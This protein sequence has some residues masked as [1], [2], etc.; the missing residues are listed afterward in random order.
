M[1]KTVRIVSLEDSEKDVELI[2]Q[3]L[4]QADIAVLFKRVANRED[5][6]K[7]LEDFQP[8]LILSDYTLADYDGM[9]AMAELQ[10]KKL[11]VPFIFVSWVIHEQSVIE[12][13][14]KGATDYI[15]KDQLPHLPFSVY[16][17][18][19]EA[20]ERKALDEAHANIQ[21]REAYFRALIENAADI[22]MVLDEKG[23]IDFASPSVHR[24]LGH[25]S[26]FLTGKNI[27]EY[28]HEDDREF[29]LDLFQ[30]DPKK[31]AESV[32]FRF[33]HRSGVWRNIEA[34]ATTTPDSGGVMR[35]ILNA[36]DMTDRHEEQEALK[37]SVIRHLK[38]QTELQNTQK[39]IIE[40]ERLSAIGQ[41]ASGI[42]HDFSNSLMPVLGFSE[43]LLNGIDK[44]ESK[45]NI[46]KYLEIINTSAKDAMQIIGQLREF[47]RTKEKAEALKPVD[48]NKIVEQ[49][50]LLTHPKWR[51]ES[52]AHGITIHVRA[53]SGNIPEVFGNETALR[54]AFTNIIFNAVDAMPVGGEIVFKTRQEGN[55]VVIE[56]SD[57]GVGMDEETYQKCFEPFFTTKGKSG[58]GLGLAM[59]YGVVRR[60]EGAID[61]KSTLGKGTTFTVR[62]PIKKYEREAG[63]KQSAVLPKFSAEKKIKKLHVLVV[64][65]E[66][67]VKEVLRGYLKIDGHTLETAKDG[68][69]GFEV[70]KA[71]KFDLVITDRAMPEMNGDQLA[72]KIKEHSPL[73]PV[74]MLTGFGE[75]M[76][77]KGESPRG[78]DILLSKPLSIAAY[79]EAIS[80]IFAP[81]DAPTS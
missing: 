18:L 36:R 65:D 9:S 25:E 17:A 56:V 11:S 5:F 60:H 74:V 78:I 1:D 32:D 13:L 53:E 66:F 28:V 73:M 42:A 24:V 70:F 52:F 76:K 45:E 51:D 7:A 15:F 44:D 72:E 79:R 48:I 46:K 2:A 61:V 4:R 43:I 23:H 20:E 16:R 26:S 27:L 80:K 34:Y 40:Q 62:I 59:V 38:M 21:E 57:T 49:V 50:I 68:K 47:Y 19:R 63:P 75:L 55:D 41:M 12:A 30:Q 22:I 31:A 6:V 58:T 69:E 39:K 71:G 10:E 37:E 8:D 14:K 77:A 35:A 81:H 54:E 33:M 67:S 29:L 64:D 3:E